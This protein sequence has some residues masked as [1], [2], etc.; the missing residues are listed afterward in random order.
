MADPRVFV[1]SVVEGFEDYREAAREGIE[2]AGGEPVLVNEDFPSVPASPRNACLDAVASSDMY[3]AIIGERA[4]WTAPSRKPVVEEEFEEACRHDMPVVLFLVEGEREEE[5]RRLAKRLSKYV[6]GYLRVE[7]RG[8]EELRAEV[9]RSLNRFID[10]TGEEQTDVQHIQEAVSDPYDLGGRPSLRVALAPERQ[11]EVVDP[12]TLGSKE[13]RYDIYRLAHSLDVE[14][15][16]YE[17]ART[18][19]LTPS[20]IVLTQRS[21]G[22]QGRGK[23]TVRIEIGQDG[24]I[25]VDG[26][27]TEPGRRTVSDAIVSAK[28]ESAAEKAFAFTEALYDEIDEFGR[29]QKFY[30]NAALS[31]LGHRPIVDQHDSDQQAT[32][33]QPVAQDDSV[34]AFSSPRDLS[35]NALRGP[36]E[37]I[38]RII[39]VIRRKREASGRRGGL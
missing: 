39:T 34:V 11:E 30:Y 12:M 19:S 31:N 24:L 21:S 2:A 29:H 23:E 27:V 14:L 5:A 18:H 35:R 22:R 17:Q 4:G 26:A 3:L 9:E 6:E 16:D 28:V 37:E 20:S 25:V 38:E 36:E 15:L 13:F 7:V 1:S 8:P 10:D 32:L 33:V